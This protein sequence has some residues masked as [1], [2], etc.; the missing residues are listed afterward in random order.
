[1]GLG[2]DARDTRDAVE[3]A[4]VETLEPRRASSGDREKE[5]LW[6]EGTDSEDDDIVQPYVMRI[7]VVV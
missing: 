7:C 6:E 2:E 3:V 4:G 1:M 5:L